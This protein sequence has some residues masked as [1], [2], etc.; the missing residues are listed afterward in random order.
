MRVVLGSLIFFIGFLFSQLG[1]WY[2]DVDW[3]NTVYVS[4]GWPLAVVLIGIGLI[5]SAPL[6]NRRD[7]VLVGWFA[8]GLCGCLL[9][10]PLFMAK[11]AQERFDEQF[12]KE[13][14]SRQ[15]ALQGELR[16]QA[17][18]ALDEVRSARSTRPKDRFTQYEGRID[19]LSLEKIRALDQKMG[20]ALKRK[21]DDYKEALNTYP[22]RGPDTWI[23]FRTR[24]ELEDE[25]LAHQKL[26]EAARGFTQFVES[27]EDSYTE[28]VDQ[29]ALK[30]PADR[31]AVAEMQRILL[32]AEANKV[33]ELRKLDVEAIGAALAALNILL[34]QWGEWSY[35]R[36]EQS[37]S[38]A[39]S[40]SEAS[41][42]QA[43]QRLVVATEAVQ[44]ITRPPKD[45]N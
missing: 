7:P 10:L 26:Y 32:F 29:L 21:S 14:S 36:R 42:H 38:F 30:P 22:T 28:A 15:K 18:A 3:F 40:A 17:Q 13:I 12:A 4:T 45:E 39:N 43:L 23:T 35:D 41:F 44:N 9:L 16:R 24:E 33:Y 6:I 19:V 34:E 20:D 8:F 31:V 25:R 2:P 5:L 27:F 37:L 1:A 11:L